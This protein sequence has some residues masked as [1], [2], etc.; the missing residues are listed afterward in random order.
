MESIRKIAFDVVIIAAGIFT[1]V[2]VYQVY[3]ESIRN[4]FFDESSNVVIFVENL[5]VSVS[6]ADS[7]AERTQGLSGV[8][9]LGDLEGKL[10]IF[11]QEANHS[12]WMK[13]M[14]FPIDIIYI[15]ENFLVVDIHENVSP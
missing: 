2:Y 9:S 6:I 8:R 15:D 5:A 11:D 12:I 7:Q 1:A 4:F 3:G 14:H 10:F 13:D